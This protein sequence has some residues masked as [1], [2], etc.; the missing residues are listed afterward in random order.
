M[1]QL[2]M[3]GDSLVEWGDWQK[4]LP[5]IE[6]INR[7]LAGETTGELAVRLMDEID[8]CPAPDAVLL[9]SGTNDLLSGDLFFPAIFTTMVPRLRLFYPDCPLIICSLTPMPIVPAPDLERV[10]R[11]L[12]QAAA[13]IPN[14]IFLDLVAPFSEQCLPIT[15]PGFLND[16]V[17]LS[18]R[19]YQVWAGA[20]SH[21]LREL[22]PQYP[23]G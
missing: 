23:Q 10:N 20:I 15:H 7:G 9:Q 21:C 3:L 18:T 19:G 14:C 12:A 4:F 5:D 1:I 11:D 8:V 6:V 13:A 16:N 22:F 2:L 17:H